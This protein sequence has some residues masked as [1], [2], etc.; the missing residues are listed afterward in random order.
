[1]TV[2]T[3]VPSNK[4][5]FALG[6]QSAYGSPVAN[7]DWQIPA[8]DAD[9]GETQELADLELIN[10]DVF[11]PGQY[12]TGA[13]FGGTVTFAS[14]PDSTPRLLAAHFGTSSDTMTGAGDPRTHTFARKDTDLPHTFWIGR[15][16]AGG[17][18][19]YTKGVDVNC[20][21]VT[22]QYDVGQLFK[23]GTT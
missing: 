13:G 18:F 20:T 19:E 8:Y 3:V 15:P 11:L 2:A 4:Y 23:I 5:T 10:G 22:F 12:K 1:M 17:T 6:K 16:V 14:H 9:I 21:Q 7:P